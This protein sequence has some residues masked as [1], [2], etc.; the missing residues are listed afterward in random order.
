MAKVLRERDAKGSAF[1]SNEELGGI[2]ADAYAE[3]FRAAWPGNL[4]QLE[5]SVAQL[6]E[7]ARIRKL[8]QIDKSCVID[9][10]KNSLG[11]ALDAGET[12]TALS[13]RPAPSSA[14]SQES[15]IQRLSFADL[16]NETRM[17]FEEEIAA[18]LVERMGEY[19][20]DAFALAESWVRGKSKR[21]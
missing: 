14:T 20:E 3:L 1:N 13:T 11:A 8:N 6:V 10:L 15:S 12:S 5:N 4:R 9:G 18:F 21:E 2:T 19:I 16:D 17:I 7:I